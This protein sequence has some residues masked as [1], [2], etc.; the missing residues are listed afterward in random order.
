[1][2]SYTHDVL[3]NENVTLE[4]FKNLPDDERL[5]IAFA[6][7]VRVAE[8]ED[9]KLKLTVFEVYDF[10]LQVAIDQQTGKVIYYE[11]MKHFDIRE[12]KKR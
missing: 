3:I 4:E 1:M 5:Y 11:A 12:F 9:G 6:E 7:G 2:V 8:V 10:F